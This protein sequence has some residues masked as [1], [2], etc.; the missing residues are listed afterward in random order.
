MNGIEICLNPVNYSFLISQ[1]PRPSGRGLKKG[2][3][4][5]AASIPTLP[6]GALKG[7]GKH[8]YCELTDYEFQFKSQK[9]S[10]YRKKKLSYTIQ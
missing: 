10:K 7:G 4:S 6:G 9:Y 2:I 1:R 5:L 3:N 8:F